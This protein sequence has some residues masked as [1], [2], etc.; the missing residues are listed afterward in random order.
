[1]D[2]ILSRINLTSS[3]VIDAIGVFWRFKVATIDGNDLTVSNIVIA[4]IIFIIGFRLSKRISRLIV[5]TIPTMADVSDNTRSAIESV[6]FYILLVVFI[7]TSL[8]IAQIPL[9][10]FALLGGA[11]AIGFGF[12]SQ[13]IIKN[14][15]SGLILMVEQPIRV[16]DIITTDGTDG[17]VI[18]VGAR[19]T[20]IRTYDNVDILIPNSTLLENNVVNW[21]LSDND[22]R[23]R[24]K[25][26]VSYGSDSRKVEALLKEV[27]NNND[28]VLN[29][30]PV[31]AYFE[32][33]GDN[34]LNFEVQFWCY[35]SRP[36]LRREAESSIRHDIY[37]AFNKEG[38]EISFPQRDVHLYAKSPIE[39]K[40]KN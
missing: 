30:R 39:V 38:I 18:K 26:G 34:S 32:D 22:I 12:G 20:H 36:S 29:S 37:E 28:K 10:S 1:M 19:S 40:V 17:Q 11:L 15:I 31:M 4:I 24:I 27:V 8:S 6:A 14:F 35:M 3:V 25:I 7:F 21:T 9:N 23:T 5:K 2:E 16:G 13:N 33:F